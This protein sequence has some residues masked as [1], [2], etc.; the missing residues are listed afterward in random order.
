MTE[1]IAITLFIA[2]PVGNTFFKN[3][4]T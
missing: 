2:D 4:Y 3:K 1:E